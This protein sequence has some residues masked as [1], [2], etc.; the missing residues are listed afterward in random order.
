MRGR[1]TMFI[2]AHRM[3]TAAVADR[4]VVLRNGGIVAEGPPDRIL[5]NTGLTDDAEWV[6]VTP[7]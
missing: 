1:R 4:I 5:A 3:T 7:V 6:E 2:I